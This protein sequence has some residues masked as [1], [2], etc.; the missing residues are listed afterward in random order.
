[1]VIPDLWPHPSRT[2]SDPMPTAPRLPQSLRL[3]PWTREPRPVSVSYKAAATSYPIPF[4]QNPS[5]T[6]PLPD[7]KP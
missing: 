1:V 6:T 4:A 5:S 2:G 3:I 7:S